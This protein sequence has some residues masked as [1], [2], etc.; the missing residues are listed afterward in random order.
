MQDVSRRSFIFTA[1]AFSFF[2]LVRTEP[3]LILHNRQYLDGKSGV[4]SRPGYRHQRK[5]DYG[6][7]FE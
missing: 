2:P 5:P 1:S 7:G 4:S 6:R 3:T